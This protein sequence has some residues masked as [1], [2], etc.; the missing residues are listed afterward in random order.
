MLTDK[1]IATIIVT[2]Y[3]RVLKTLSTCQWYL[4]WN[5]QT[6]RLLIHITFCTIKL[7]LKV[8]PKSGANLYTNK[9][10]AKCLP[11]KKSAGANQGSQQTKKMLKRRHNY[12]YEMDPAWKCVLRARQADRR[13]PYNHSII[14]T[15]DGCSVGVHANNFPLRDSLRNNTKLKLCSLFDVRIDTEQY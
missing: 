4:M 7:C 15:V 3:D 8:A 6:K 12:L 11:A 9:S 5:K 14:F 1:A 2:D 10:G 13:M